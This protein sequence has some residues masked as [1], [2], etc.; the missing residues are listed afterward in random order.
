MGNVVYITI[1]DLSR[2]PSFPAAGDVDYGA[3][4]VYPGTDESAENAEGEITEEEDTDDDS[5]ENGT[6]DNDQ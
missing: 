2:I 3:V 1:G 4:A 5:T 6:P